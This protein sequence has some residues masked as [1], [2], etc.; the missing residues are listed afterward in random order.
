MSIVESQTVYPP[1]LTSRIEDVIMHIPRMFDV[2]YGYGFVD[3]YIAINA[4]FENNI[5]WYE[6]QEQNTFVT[7][8]DQPIC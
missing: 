7:N 4:P 5:Q 2:F 3:S 6:Y 1:V 8:Y